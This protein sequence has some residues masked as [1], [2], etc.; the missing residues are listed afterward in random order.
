MFVSRD[1]I[2]L[3]GGNNVFQ[4]APN[5]TGWIDPWGLSVEKIQE[6]TA[7]LPTSL[8]QNFQCDKF[9]QALRKELTEAKISFSTIE[10]NSHAGIWSN[11]INGLISENG[12]HEAIQVGDMVF[13]NIN[14]N[15]IPYNDWDIDLGVTEQGISKTYP[16]NKKGCF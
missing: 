8:K 2:G 10:L 5:P 15:G 13:D 6:I 12:F 9:A 1:P 11:R 14:P 4:Y 3:L 7:K 16:K